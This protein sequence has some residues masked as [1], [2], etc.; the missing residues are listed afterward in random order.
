MAELSSFER[1]KRWVHANVIHGDPV[2]SNVLL[3]AE[4]RI[5]L[6]D[7]RGEVG[8][9]L[10]LQGDLTYDLSKVYQS[11]LGYDYILLSQP[12]HERDA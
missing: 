7:M 1:E 4:G 12:L 3:D 8:S 9:T 2:F 6:L 10:T 11:L 5:Y